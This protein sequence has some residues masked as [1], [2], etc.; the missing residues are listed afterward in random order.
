MLAYA[1]SA[2]APAMFLVQ[3]IKNR[4]KLMGHI[5]IQL[6][7]EKINRILQENSGLGETGE[8][9]VVGKDFLMRSD[10]RFLKKGEQS[11]L[12]QKVETPGVTKAF[13][14]HNE[15]SN[16][17]N[18]RGVEVYSAYGKMGFHDK[19]G[20]DWDW[21]FMSEI[22]VEEVERPIKFLLAWIIT[23]AAI[24]LIISLT[25]AIWFAKQIS[26][27]L[28]KVITSA[29]KI[30][31][32]DLEKTNTT[33]NS[34]DELASLANSFILM[35]NNLYA[36]QEILQSIASGNGDLT[37]NVPLASQNDTL[38]KV[39]EEVLNSIN[40]LIL[41]IK[42]STNKVTSVA[43][44]VQA[45]SQSL[46]EDSAN[47]ASILEEIHSSVIEIEN[48]AKDNATA[49]SNAKTF[50]QMASEAAEKGTLSMKEVNDIM[51]IISKNANE[52]SKVTKTIDDIAF[53]INLLSLNAAVEAARA[54]EHGKGFAVV[55]EEVR[56]LANRS[57][58][59][60]SET[61]ELISTATNNI[62]LGDEKVEKTMEKLTNISTVV[63]KINDIIDKMAD[64]N[65]SQAAGLSE[66]G[67]ALDQIDHL[68]QENAK[69]AAS[70]AE[71]STTL[72]EN[73]SEL[74]NRISRF[75]LK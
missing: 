36:K 55:A 64:S 1:P 20:T 6:P 32:G 30:S 53:Q 65:E 73:A 63:N 5:A 43:I 24:L 75:K 51:T 35:Q 50:S 42:N 15:I 60:A 11:T 74:F 57:A 71:I 22:N 47:Q 58:K 28:L 61:S 25:V 7:N 56:S 41:E 69:N 33:I 67:I 34:D 8:T 13:D 44:N 19:F 23:F 72:Q 9:Y 18:Y 52:I 68:T 66:I 3:P 17:P 38:G 49:S 29:Q 31:D 45:S 70:N 10:S 62:R 12:R 21:A 39:I 16:F 27:P 2:D 26:N 4:S 40:E 54:G 48:T 46:N 37:I 14:G 59:S